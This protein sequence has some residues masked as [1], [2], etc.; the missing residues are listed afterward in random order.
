MKTTFKT[1]QTCFENFKK[2]NNIDTVKTF[3]NV[4][5]EKGERIY[6]EQGKAKQKIVKMKVVLELFL[7][8]EEDLEIINLKDGSQFL[9]VLPNREGKRHK[10]ILH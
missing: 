6:D 2:Q 3:D 7:T 4:Y 5:N 1:V 10:L 9:S 8:Y